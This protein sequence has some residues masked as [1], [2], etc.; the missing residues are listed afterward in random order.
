MLQKIINWILSLFRPSET[1]ELDEAIEAK[2]DAIK[3]IDKELDDEYD[4]VNEAL[5][6][7]KK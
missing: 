5:D 7:W 4:T 6:E 3:D 2:K 1:P